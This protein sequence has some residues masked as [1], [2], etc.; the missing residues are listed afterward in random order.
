[1]TRFVRL[2]IVLG[3]ALPSLAGAQG[4]ANFSGTWTLSVT[5]PPLTPPAGPGAGA[6]GGGAV[7][8][9]NAFGAVTKTV[10]ITQ[11]SNEADGADRIDEGRLQAR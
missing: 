7:Y 11:T 6:G 9:E 5:D 10:V 8:D 2:A 1:M 3:L 4:P